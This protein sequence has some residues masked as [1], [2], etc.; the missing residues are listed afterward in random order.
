[1]VIPSAGRGEKAQSPSHHH[2]NNLMA[3]QDQP[4]DFELLFRCAPSLLLVLAPTPEYT[5]L[6]A[7][8][9]YL[10]AM[11]SV[12]GRIVGRALFDVFPETPEGSRTTGFGS[13]KAALDRVLATRTPDAMNAPVFSA[14]G[15]L[16]YIIHRVDAIELEV[17]RSARERDEAIRQLK[18]ANEEL[19]AF[20]YS[21]SHDLQ[22]PLRAIEDFCQAYEQK[23]GADLEPAMRQLLTRITSNVRRMES[24]IDDLLALSRIG[25]VQLL[26]ARVDVTAIALGVVE[27][28]KA[29]DPDRS[30]TVEIAGG[31][32]AWADPGL[33]AI[34]LGNLIGN[35][36]KYTSRRESAHLQV[37]RRVVVGQ[38]VFYVRDNGVGFD[39]ALAGKLFK[40]F[41]RLHGDADFS[42]HGI[43]L[44]IVKR[45]VERHGGEIWAESQPDLGATFHF[46]LAAPLA[47]VPAG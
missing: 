38:D 43:G 47:A 30:V 7:S 3:E 36:W 37:G 6:G 34:A 44:A 9:A 41:A 15:R 39:L 21:A 13:L 12:R 28:L 32:E 35:A 23:S 16:R 18:S 11:R 14:D 40:P 10:R 45:I 8:D 42:G 27:E 22:A 46:T 1:M 20:V 2:S 25:R 31:L 24:I 26:R 17:L 19:E 29:A 4:L 33:A 5:I